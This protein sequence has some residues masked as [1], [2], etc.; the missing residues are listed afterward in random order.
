MTEEELKQKKEKYVKEVYE[1][2]GE[3]CQDPKE[4]VAFWQELY[5]PEVIEQLERQRRWAVILGPLGVA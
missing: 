1:R 3:L 2:L 4:T 5:T